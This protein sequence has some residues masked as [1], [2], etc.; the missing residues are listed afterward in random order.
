METRIEKRR[1]QYGNNKSA[2][3]VK[4]KKFINRKENPPRSQI[5]KNTQ[6]SL[7]YGLHLHK[8]FHLLNAT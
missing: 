7:I 8:F 4:E 6:N 1:L 2:R 5:D 3:T